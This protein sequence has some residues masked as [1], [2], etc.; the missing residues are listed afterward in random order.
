MRSAVKMKTF[1]Q[2]PGNKSCHSVLESFG[3][4]PGKPMAVV[5]EGGILKAAATPTY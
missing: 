1:T 4:L 5:V 3:L 2:F